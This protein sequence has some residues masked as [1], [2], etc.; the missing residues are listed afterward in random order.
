MFE[1]IKSIFK[2]HR[3]A[4][5]AVSVMQLFTF[6]PAATIFW[7]TRENHI[8]YFMFAGAIAVIASWVFH[9][10]TKDVRDSVKH[11][12]I[13]MI[14]LFIILAFL[15]APV[16]LTFYFKVAIYFANFFVVVYP[17]DYRG[18]DRLISFLVVFAFYNLFFLVDYI[19][20]IVKLFRKQPSNL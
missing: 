14:I 8:Y 11:F 5:T 15:A 13:K 19:K 9:W 17:S 12:N 6:I 20:S 4:F 10:T 1:I 3:G 2:Y 18:P 16:L 7:T